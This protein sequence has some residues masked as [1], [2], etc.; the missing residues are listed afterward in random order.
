LIPSPPG[1]TTAYTLSSAH[2]SP[3]DS[4]NTSFSLSNLAYGVDL[5][6]SISGSLEKEI[7]ASVSEV[8]R[9][10]FKATVR[11]NIQ[12]AIEEGESKLREVGIELPVYLRGT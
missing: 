5:L 8:L 9:R 11:V 3:F 1:S 4:I 7:A 12:V 2:L 6:N 10:F